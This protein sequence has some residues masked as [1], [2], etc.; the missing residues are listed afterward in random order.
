MTL[1]MLLNQI[2][3]DLITALK[4]G[5]KTRVGTLRFLVAAVKKYEIDTYPPSSGGKL[6]DAD[7]SRIVQRQ[8]K[9]HRESIEAFTKAN[10][11]DLVDKEKQELEILIEY[12]PKELTDAEI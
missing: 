4:A 3:T 10:R 7:T 6:T 8:V 9:T 2:Q 5:D 11:Q 1:N 12:M